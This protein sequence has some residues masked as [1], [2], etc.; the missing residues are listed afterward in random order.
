MKRK[1]NID[2][3]IEK[4]SKKTGLKYIVWQG[5]NLQGWRKLPIYF[6]ED[7]YETD[8]NKIHKVGIKYALK[9]KKEILFS[10]WKCDLWS[11]GTIARIGYVGYVIYVRVYQEFPN[12]YQYPHLDKKG[13][14]KEGSKKEKK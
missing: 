10:K 1:S 9:I 3:L 13:K 12:G 4:I 5:L 8:I 14:F 7:M 11:I 6:M 2:H